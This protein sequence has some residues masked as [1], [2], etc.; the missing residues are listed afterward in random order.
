MSI[1]TLPSLGF[2]EAMMDLTVEVATS[3]G[4]ICFNVLNA[5]FLSFPG[6]FEFFWYISTQWSEQ[7]FR[8]PGG[9]SLD[10]Q[11]NRQFS[12]APMNLEHFLFVCLNIREVFKIFLTKC[13]DIFQR[14]VYC[15]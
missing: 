12:K 7:G 6:S 11:S 10:L 13:L 4:L 9:N 5:L 14:V 3:G 15:T 2:A 1:F 8:A